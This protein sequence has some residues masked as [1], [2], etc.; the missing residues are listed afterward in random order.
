MDRVPLGRFAPG[1]RRLGLAV[2]P[3]YTEMMA[4]APRTAL[5]WR[6]TTRRLFQALL[7]DRYRVVDFVR[8]ERG[9]GT[10]VLEQD[11]E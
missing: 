3:R 2:P 9:G 1:G 8:D 7:A 10:Y 11:V 6:L 4:S 5:A